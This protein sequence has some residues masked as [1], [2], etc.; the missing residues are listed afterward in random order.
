MP[1]KLT[2]D[3]LIKLGQLL[4]YPLSFDGLCQG[5]SAM[6]IQAWLGKNEKT[7]FGRLKLIESYRKNFNKLKVD[8]GN[9]RDL[10]KSGAIKNLDAVIREKKMQLLEIPALFE[11]IEL[12]LNPDKHSQLFNQ[13]TN[14]T[15]VEFIA[16]FTVPSSFKKKD[17]IAKVF[18]KSY[19]FNKNTLLEHL[20]DLETQFRRTN[21][22]APVF[23]AS[24]DHCVCVKYDKQRNHW[25]FVDTNEFVYYPHI[26]SYFSIVTKERLVHKLFDAFDRGTKTCPNRIFTT[27]IVAKQSESSALKSAFA[28]MEQR[29]PVTQKLV[30]KRDVQGLN[31]LSIACINNEVKVV[32]AFLLLNN[33]RVNQADKYGWTPLISACQHGHLKIVQALLTHPDIKVN[34]ATK[35]GTTPLFEAC[36]NGNVKVVQ[37]LLARPEILV[38]KKKKNGATP[39][40]MACNRGHI[41]IVKELLKHPQL[42]INL[43]E[44]NPLFDAC[45]Y[46]DSELVEELLKHKKVKVNQ[47][48][49]NGAT[50]LHHACMYG[51]SKIV[52]LIVNSDRLQT[53][54]QVDKAGYTPLHIACDN[55]NTNVVKAL[56]NSNRIRKL[57]A[58]TNSGKTP[59]MLACDAA[60][61]NKSLIQILLQKGVNIKHKNRFGMSALDYAFEKNNKTAM[62]AILEHAAVQKVDIRSIV[63]IK[64]FPGIQNF[65]AS[66]E[67]VLTLENE[68]TAEASPPDNPKMPVAEDSDA[69]PEAPDESTGYTQ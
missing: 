12:Y 43:A 52:E 6:L 63:G 35:N 67:Q 24:I 1:A 37:E 61:T 23:F 17:E 7:F 40:G 26:P 34:Q 36:G 55:R 32:E 68:Q 33:I 3:D 62:E 16:P 66:Q 49:L 20:T 15:E 8:I 69:F 29:Y 44:E 57:N 14:Q 48:D 58:E 60:K 10:V 5:F 64:N 45:N 47:A 31:L 19:A 30:G 28:K 51:R 53:I 56:L 54:N 59:L 4:G 38:N 50:P 18:D 22:I 46:G 27:T 2:H 41:N 21:V 9:A 42:K 13:A 39:I 11:G 25:I 65:M